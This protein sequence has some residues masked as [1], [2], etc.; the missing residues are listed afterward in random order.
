MTEANYFYYLNQSGC[1]EVEGTDD[2]AEFQETL[3]AMQ[4]IGKEAEALT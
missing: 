1:Y 3:E 2:R 4:V